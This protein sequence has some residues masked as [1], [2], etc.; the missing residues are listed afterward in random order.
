MTDVPRAPHPFLEVGEL[1]GGLGTSERHG[2]PAFV[3]SLL[4]GLGKQ[5]A[6]A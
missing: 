1:M 5:E 2:V 6:V 4:F 3:F